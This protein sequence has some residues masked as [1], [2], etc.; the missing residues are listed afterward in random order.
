MSYNYRIL[1]AH[2]AIFRNGVADEFALLKRPAEF[3][4]Q[5]RRNETKKTGT[6]QPM[7][8]IEMDIEK[9]IL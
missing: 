8:L 2:K 5:K 1:C 4:F 7:F 3:E 9:L 6:N